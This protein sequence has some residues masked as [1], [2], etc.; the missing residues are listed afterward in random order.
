M[1]V[2]RKRTDASSDESNADDISYLRQ[3]ILSVCRLGNEKVHGRPSFHELKA[4]IRRAY[5]AEEATVLLA[6]VSQREGDKAAFW[7]ELEACEGKREVSPPLDADMH[8][9]VRL[10]ARAEAQK[11]VATRM[12]LREKKKSQ[13]VGSHRRVHLFDANG[14]M[15]KALEM[16]EALPQGT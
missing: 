16:I 11:H 5:H 6:Y 15:E 7:A 12:L 3:N 4:R 8:T 14:S 9:Y 10:L 13:R 1:S 2:K